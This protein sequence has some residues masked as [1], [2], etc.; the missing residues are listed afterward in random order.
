MFTRFQIIVA[1]TLLSAI[2]AAAQQYVVR[3]PTTGAYVSRPGGLFVRGG[4][5][6]TRSTVNYYS[7]AY[8]FGNDYTGN[9]YRPFSDLSYV[10]EGYYYPHYTGDTLRTPLSA[11]APAPV[12]PIPNITGV[13]PYTPGYTYPDLINPSTNPT[14]RPTRR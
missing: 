14:Y 12:A 11:P 13:S 3:G 10:Y 4:T 5:P 8:G 2:P 9:Y 1:A 7:F 6:G